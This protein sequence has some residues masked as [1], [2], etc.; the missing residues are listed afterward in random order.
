MRAQTEIQS[1]HDE[2]TRK[3]LANNATVGEDVARTVLGWVLSPQVHHAELVSFMGT[4]DEE[5]AC[6]LSHCENGDCND[7][8]E[9]HCVKDSKGK[10]D[11]CS[12]VHCGIDTLC[13]PLTGTG[14]PLIPDIDALRALW[15]GKYVRTE[16]VLTREEFATWVGDPDKDM[17]AGKWREGYT[18]G[19]AGIV[20][21][22][23]FERGHVW[24]DTDEG[25]SWRIDAQTRIAEDIDF[26]AKRIEGDEYRK[27]CGC[28]LGKG[29]FRCCRLCDADAH[30]CPGC[31]KP[32]PHEWHC[33]VECRTQA[34]K[35][36][37]A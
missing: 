2:L 31:G 25:L 10:C 9:Q 36:A 32:T 13:I 3:Y 17:G 27:P 20:V 35:E 7:C 21:G 14:V 11:N 8:D 18:W 34:T 19:G 12:A 4:I 22:F 5:S 26:S 29:C 37:A 6:K 23:R 1:T 15:V 28:K 33:C 24:L 30:R 16:R